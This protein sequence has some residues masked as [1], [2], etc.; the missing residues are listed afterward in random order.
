MG[1]F[2][3]VSTGN[4]TLSTDINQYGNILNGSTNGY[5]VIV[6]AAGSNIPVST[7]LATAPV[8]DGGVFGGSVTGDSTNRVILYIRGADGYGAIECGA[9]S[10]ITARMYAQ[11]S[12]WKIDQALNVVGNVTGGSLNVG[13]VSV[14]SGNISA[15]SGSITGNTLV[16]NSAGGN[17]YYGSQNFSGTGS[18]TYTHGL[19]AAPNFVGVIQNVSNSTTTV[20]VDS[21]GST[22][23]HVNINGSFAF[24]AH[25]IKN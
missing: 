7:Q 13:S 14:S 3:L 5:L 18:G 10:S 4:N 21:I 9:G 20:G 11:A 8:S 6:N 22:T 25:A 16:A 19:S 12:G 23:C 24:L 15:A 17:T 2:T 1:S